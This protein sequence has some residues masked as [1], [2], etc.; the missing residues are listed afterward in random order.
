MM[1]LFSFSFFLIHFFIFQS[2]H[3]Q[4]TFYIKERP[5]KNKH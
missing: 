1:A 2:K 5:L 4:C 3:T